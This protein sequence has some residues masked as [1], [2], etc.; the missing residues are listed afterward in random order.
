M[1]DDIISTHAGNAAQTYGRRVALIVRRVARI[2]AVPALLLML[3][4]LLA[5]SI[6]SGQLLGRAWAGFPGPGT[7]VLV[8]PGGLSERLFS[9]EAA[10]SLGL[11]AL[12]LVPAIT[13]FLILVDHLRGRR[14]KEAVVAAS[15]VAIMALSAVLGKK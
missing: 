13:V 7:V 14:W 6:S 4:G 1:L 10:M 12:A 2:V 8:H 5:Y 15:V 9:G 3:G 11:L